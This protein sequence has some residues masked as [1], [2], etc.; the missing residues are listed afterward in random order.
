LLFLSICKILSLRQARDHAYAILLAFVMLLA[1]SVITN[2]EIYMLFI[3]G[4]LALAMTGLACSTMAREAA[5]MKPE[6]DSAALE[7]L[8]DPRILD[9]D[10]ALAP[11]LFASQAALTLAVM[12]VAYCLFFFMPHFTTRAMTTTFLQATP[13]RQDAPAVSGFTDN[14]NLN[15]INQ[16]VLDNT[17]VMTVTVHWE[18]GTDR[19]MPDHIR[20]RGSNLAVFN[21]NSWRSTFLPR[22]ISS[23][24]WRVVN[25]AR[26]VTEQEPI[27]DQDISQNMQLTQRLFGADAPI[28]FLDLDAFNLSLNYETQAVDAIMRGPGPWGSYRARSVVPPDGMLTMSRMA[29]AIVQAPP[30]TRRMNDGVEQIRRLRRIQPALPE[31][32]PDMILDAREKAFYTALPPG[33]LTDVIRPLAMEHAAGVSLAWRVV[34]LY[35]WFQA[36]FQYSLTPRTPANMHP[37]E[38]FLLRTHQGHCEYFASA[39]ALM[40]RACHIPARVVTGFYSTEFN[41]LTNQFMIRQSDAH[42]WCEAWVDGWGWV[43]LDPTPPESRGRAP[44]QS[45]R[46]PFMTRLKQ[47]IHDLWQHDVLDYSNGDKAAYLVYWL[48]RPL[49]RKFGA[50]N[51]WLKQSLEQG[52]SD[53][54]VA[55]QLGLDLS[56]DVVRSMFL[57]VLPIALLVILW[58]LYR[59]SLRLRRAADARLSTVPFMNRL[60]RQLESLGWKRLPSQ[61]TAEFLGQIERQAAGRWPLRDVLELYHRARYGCV[62]PSP[63]ELAWAR[64]TIHS[65][66]K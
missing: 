26:T 41:R 47:D 48:R 25:M 19:R 20:L 54:W 28:Q 18:D 7:A 13:A 2:S 24:S 14:L 42:A 34:N 4:F 65:I 38:A 15:A 12:A 31:P 33:R 44:L 60:I 52:F 55:R 46:P 8:F 36:D 3:L 16:V 50:L 53:H 29:G 5:A 9:L 21:G 11:R 35:H 66:H 10:R 23:S 58:G 49:R 32:D 63:A 64:K 37:L 40:L 56:Q 51:A 6:P 59:H 1:C 22:Y 17:H 62:E 57:S 43:T 45:Y 61:T 30:E 27:L 39:M